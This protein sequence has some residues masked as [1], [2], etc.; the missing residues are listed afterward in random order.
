[1][2]NISFR[3]LDNISPPE[4][5]GIE[6]FLQKTLLTRDE[7]VVDWGIEAKEDMFV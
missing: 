4:Q 5:T 1:M 6:I 2:C 7:C 3:S